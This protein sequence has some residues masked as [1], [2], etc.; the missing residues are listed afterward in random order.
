M[1]IAAVSLEKALSTLEAELVEMDRDAAALRKWVSAARKAAHQGTIGEIGKAIEQGQ[2]RAA[3]LQ[4]RLAKA[5]THIAFDPVEYLASD[6]Y[7]DELKEAAQAAGLALID[8]DG[9]L[10]AF[11]LLLKRDPKSLAVRV[12]RKAD[13]RIR[14]SF[15]VAQLKASQDR[16]SGF[17]AAD[18]LKALFGAYQRLSRQFGA[19]YGASSTGLGPV[20]PLLDIYDTLTLMRRASIRSRNSA[21]TCCC[22]TAS[23]SWSRRP[24]TVSG[25]R[26]RRAA[27]RPR[28]SRSMTRPG[29]NMCMWACSSWARDGDPAGRMARLFRGR[30]SDELYPGRRV[31]R[32][33][34]DHP[35]GEPGGAVVAA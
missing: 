3:A 32:E 23:R 34:R 4:E 18:F 2:S 10:S 13:R 21:A 22:S 5:G 27:S 9:R 31:R 7:L 33:I 1:E 28:K 19:A 16:S 29:P 35:A 12:N 30:L 11:P 24:V 25:C 20:A 8:R 15:L 14:P 26:R 17:K 6:A